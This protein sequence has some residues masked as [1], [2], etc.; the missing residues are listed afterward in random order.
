M[1]EALENAPT[2]QTPT[3]TVDRNDGRVD[4]VPAPA[5]GAS[6][7]RDRAAVDDELA[8]GDRAGA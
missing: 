1:S 4:P 7:G 5:R 2:A 8:A 6:H 3:G